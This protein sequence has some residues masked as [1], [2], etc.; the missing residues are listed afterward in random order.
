[1]PFWHIFCYPEVQRD[2][3]KFDHRLSA[4]HKPLCP[5]D[6]YIWDEKTGIWMTI[7]DQIIPLS[8]KQ[9]EHNLRWFTLP[10]FNNACQWQRLVSSSPTERAPF[11]PS[12]SWTLPPPS[13]STSRDELKFEIFLFARANG[14]EIGYIIWYEGITI[15]FDGRM[16]HFRKR[17][18]PRTK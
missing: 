12:S 3:L 15:L 17:G 11:V 6:R 9:D 14:D 18:R 7:P 10:H 13:P 4:L 16:I 1:M 2:I 5:S 8:T